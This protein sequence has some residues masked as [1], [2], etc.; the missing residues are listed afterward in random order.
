M[1]ASGIK[2]NSP[3]RACPNCGQSAQEV[4]LRQ[5][6]Y[7][8]SQCGFEMAHLDVGPNGAIRGVLGY[9]LHTGEM[10]HDRYRIKKVLGKGGFGATYLVNDLTVNGKR[11]ALKE[12][13]EQ[14]FDEHE[15]DILSQMSHPAIP[16][17]TDRFVENGMVYLVLEFGG[18]HTLRSECKQLGGRLPM[19]MVISVMRQLCDALEYIHSRDPPVIHRDLKPDNI[20]LDDDGR[21]M[22]IDFGIA[23]KADPVATT[24]VV[25][26]AVSHGFSPPEQI[27]GT[28]TD[29][30]SDI[31]SFG[32]TLYYLLTGE[33][34]VASHERMTGRGIVPPSRFVAGLPPGLE[35]LLLSS[36]SLNPNQ[37]P[38]KIEGLKQ[39]I[40]SLD[41]LVSIETQHV[42]RTV[43]FDPTEGRLASI[44]PGIPVRGVKIGRG[45]ENRSRIRIV[46]IILAL[47]LIAGAAGLVG[48]SIGRGKNTEEDG[49][50]T[51]P[52]VTATTPTTTGSIPPPNSSGKKTE[53]FPPGK[54]R[55]YP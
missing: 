44:H 3:D 7:V 4:A 54:A 20:L 31:F 8:C 30:R 39:M 48:L 55:T 29:E 5:T 26:R 33:A 43:R 18:D 46:T 27:L 6:Q 28:G 11:R 15:A 23:K 40:R 36:L 45:P 34:P 41:G 49:G 38:G 12:I 51:A 16:D 32:A 9:L 13:P 10:L 37:R 47:V 21:I 35:D 52:T 53:P 2:V 25:A 1:S 17:I 24:R 50:T 19:Q 14:L 22:L 42:S